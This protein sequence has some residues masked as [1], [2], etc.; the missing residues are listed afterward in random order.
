MASALGTREPYG[1]R[2]PRF[3]RRRALALA[4]LVGPGAGAQTRV[5]DARTHHLRSGARAE[6]QER[7]THPHPRRLALDFRSTSGAEHTLSIRQED[8]KQRWDVVLNGRVLGQ[9]QQ[10][11]NPI[12]A[13]WPLPVGALRAGTN[14]LRVEPADTIA[15]DVWVRGITLLDAPLEDVLSQ[16]SVEV[17]VVDADGGEP[18]PARVTVVDT[19]GALQTVGGASARGRAIR[20]GIVYTGDGRA[21]FGLPAGAYRI[22]ASRGFEYGVD[23]ARLVLRR[24]DRVRRRL[25]V[26]HEVPT[27]GWVASDTHVHSLTYSRHGDATAEER[28]VTLAGEGV[29]LPIVTEHNVQVDLDS[30]ARAAGVRDFFTPVVGNEVTTRVGHFNVWPLTVRAPVPD[31]QVRSWDAAFRTIE[32]TGAHAVILNHA[33]DIHAGFRPFDPARHV[34]IAG[35]ALDGWELRANAMEVVNSGAQQTDVHRLLLDW[36]GMLNAGHRLTPVGASD[37]HDVGR[38]VVGQARTYIRTRDEAPGRID[39][40]D[41]AERFRDGA[42]MVSFG[43]L[44]ELTVAD[45]FGPG[46]VVPATASLRVDVRVLGPAWTRADRI[47]LYANGRPIR[48]ARI[49]DRDAAGVKWRGT[50]L[51]P[52]PAHDVFLVAVAEGPGEF[53]PFWP[54]AKPYQPAAAEWSPHVIGASGAVWLDVD[55]DGRP[56]DAHAYAARAMAASSGEIGPLVDALA[57]YDD[58]VAAQA[59]A[60]LLARGVRPTR[61]AVWAALRRASPATRRGFAEFAAEWL[62][63]QPARGDPHPKTEYDAFTDSTTRSV[64]V[65]AIVDTTLAPPDSFAVEL[66]QRWK[67]RGTSPPSDAPLEL[68]LGRTSAGGLTVSRALKPSGPG[69]AAVVFLLDGGRRIRLEQSEYVSNGGERMTFETARYRISTADLRRVAESQELRVRIG[70]RELWIDPGWRRVAAEMVGGRPP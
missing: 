8:V 43:L 34:A 38:Y 35:L 33:R 70:E 21:T 20:P 50:W 18:L 63:S 52:R 55:G 67:G 26:R 39:V 49:V 61:A 69:R 32:A 60:L 51:L 30:T 36:F 37:S 53:L 4:L 47:T 28:V 6:W 44:A 5:L 54:I 13:Y 7:G 48:S 62:A 1:R 14:T 46:D 17:D 29:E 11:E 12:V 22:F 23:S 66:V 42:V 9:L 24:G 45:R 58:A 19:G 40:A 65:Y 3:P 31:S 15:D 57:P 27:P 59:A 64:S 2:S 68:G 41:A 16:A 56:T 25:V 10:D